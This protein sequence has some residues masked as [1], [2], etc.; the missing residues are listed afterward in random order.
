MGYMYDAMQGI[1]K[2]AEGY[3]KT[4]DLLTVIHNEE[5]YHQ[6]VD[7]INNLFPECLADLQ[8][9]VRENVEKK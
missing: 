8:K 2:E 1:L 6:Y 4:A 9:G 3:V 7:Y 5:E